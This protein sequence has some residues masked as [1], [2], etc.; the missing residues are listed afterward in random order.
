VPFE[1]SQFAIAFDAWVLQAVAASRFLAKLYRALKDE[2]QA[3]AAIWAGQPA[4]ERMERHGLQTHFL[5]VYQT[6]ELEHPDETEAEAAAW[7][8]LIEAQAGQCLF[9]AVQVAKNGKPTPGLLG[10]ST[11]ANKAFSR[12]LVSYRAAFPDEMVAAGVKRAL[13]EAS[14][15]GAEAFSQD[16]RDLP[17][18]DRACM[19]RDARTKFVEVLQEQAALVLAN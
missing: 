3:S 13:L 10:Q 14:R 4:T 15:L 11:A 2:Q 6:F 1:S 8:N 12:A 17:E 19:R 16:A 5:E 9:F 7:Q 18:E